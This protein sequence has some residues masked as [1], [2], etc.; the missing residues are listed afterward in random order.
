MSL[1][2]LNKQEQHE[3]TRL[4]NQVIDDDSH[5]LLLGILKQLKIMNIHLSMMTDNEIDK[6]EID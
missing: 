6:A 5:S 4:E 1:T 3:G 2:S